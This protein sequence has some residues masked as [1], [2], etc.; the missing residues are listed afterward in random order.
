[1]ADFRMQALVQMQ[2]GDNEM[3]KNNFNATYAALF[4]GVP[5]RGLNIT[6]LWAIVKEQPN[7]A[8][9]A[10]LDPTSDYLRQLHRNFC[11]K[12]KF[13]DSKIISFYET[14][15]SP[16]PEQVGRAKPLTCYL[17]IG[18]FANYSTTRWKTASGP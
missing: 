17:F 13:V 4:F 12:F 18:N 7:K 5:N 10:T 2:D 15:L 8:L 11:E 16:T 6:Y 9:V 3:D 1:M 14:S